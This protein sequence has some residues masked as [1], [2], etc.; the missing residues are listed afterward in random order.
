ML[1]I[2]SSTI[3]AG[4][5][6]VVVG[7]LLFAGVQIARASIP[8]Q[9]GIAH[10]CYT[11]NGTLRVIDLQLGQACKSNERPLDWDVRS[12]VGYQ[13][14]GAKH[15]PSPTPVVVAAVTLPPGSYTITAT[16]EINN[17]GD[18]SVLIGCFVYGENSIVAL[19]HQTVPPA[20]ATSSTLATLSATGVTEL[21]AG[22]VARME[23][24]DQSNGGAPTSLV[25][26]IVAT[27]VSGVVRQQP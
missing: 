25:G 9:G 18:V 13:G 4:S 27:G 12:T 1:R 5:V 10:A 11:G 17:V 26:T 24:S 8:D 15:L 23:C 22:G 19:V 21:Q 14:V 3:R 6:I 2:T 16:V 20:T 7:A